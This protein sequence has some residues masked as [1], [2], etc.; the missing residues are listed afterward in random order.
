MRLFT[1]FISYRSGMHYCGVYTTL[2]YL[3]NVILEMT[4]ESDEID[5]SEI[6]KLSEIYTGINGYSEDFFCEFSDGTWIHIQ[7]TSE[8]LVEI[9]Q[10]HAKRTSFI[11]ISCQNCKKLGENTC[12]DQPGT[13]CFETI[14]NQTLLKPGKIPERTNK[15]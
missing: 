10:G 13:D 2:E 4:E 5:S 15:T 14:T 8:R 6:P 9:I 1:L 3:Y 12:P 7:E 11:S